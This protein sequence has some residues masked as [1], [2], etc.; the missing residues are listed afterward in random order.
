MVGMCGRTCPYGCK[1]KDFTD[2]TEY[3]KKYH[4]EFPSQTDQTQRAG[5]ALAA[6]CD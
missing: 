6:P 5:A 3:I 2:I 1:K 4:P